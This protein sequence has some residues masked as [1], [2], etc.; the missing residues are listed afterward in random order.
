LRSPGNLSLL[1]LV[2]VAACARSPAPPVAPAGFEPLHA[3]AAAGS[4]LP[5]LHVDANE[6]VYLSW[7]EPAAECHALRYVVLAGNGWSPPRTVAQGCDWFVNWADFPSVVALGGD[8]LAAH[9]LRRRES[10]GYA[11]D[12][13]L[14]VSRDGGATWGAAFTPH[15]DDTRTQHGFV[16]LLPWGGNGLFALWLDGRA[17]AGYGEEDA[18]HHAAMSLRSAVYDGSGTLLRADE[19][20]AHTCSCCQTSAAAAGDGILIAYRDRS[21]GEIRDIA[22][23]RFTT[24]GWSG[25]SIVHADGWRIEG[26]PVNGPSVAARGAVAVVAWYTA[27]REE[28]RVWLARSEDGGVTF[29]DPVRIDEG[30]PLGRVDVALAPDGSAHVLWLEQDDARAGLRLRRVDAAGAAEPAYLLA[31]VGTSPRSGFPQLAVTT[32]GLVVAWTDDTQP[33]V[34]S[35]RSARLPLP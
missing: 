35:L 22:V 10:H 3:G 7:T 20:D 11:Y 18:E 29:G 23:Q 30:H 31:T 2:L 28:A 27:A 17:M 12:V 1:Y 4:A 26:C 16:S 8:T 6:Q 15:D 25:P 34:T 19:V 9:W 13:N 14:S 24:T 32:A 5:W 33:G 21:E